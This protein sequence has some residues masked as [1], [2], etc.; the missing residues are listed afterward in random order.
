[1]HPLIKSS[2]LK[3]V[4]KPSQHPVEGVP[5]VNGYT[6][7]KDHSGWT[8]SYNPELG[9]TAEEEARGPEELW[10][11]LRRQVHWAEEEGELLKR[12]CEAMEDIRKKEWIEKEVLLDQVIHNET[13][14]HQRREEVLK[15]M[16][17]LPSAD[18]I[19]AAAAAVLEANDPT[20]AIPQDQGKNDR[21]LPTLHIWNIRNTDVYRYS[22]A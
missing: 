14:W 4:I 3:L 19:K 21:R 11:L 9:F 17:S 10:R 20:T 22:S 7:G 5:P 2:R 8:S 16:A 18:Q 1:M 6:N 13:T 12:Q 15:G